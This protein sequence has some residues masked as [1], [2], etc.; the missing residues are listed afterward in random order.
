MDGVG[1]Q[2]GCL[3]T[4]LM[5]RLVILCVTGF[6]LGFGG[7]DFSPITFMEVNVGQLHNTLPPS[8][9]I[10]NSILYCLSKFPL[11]FPFLHEL[12]TT[13]RTVQSHCSQRHIP[14]THQGSGN[15]IN[16]GTGVL[17]NFT[18]SSLGLNGV[19]S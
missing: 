7:S 4:K 13:G 16:D 2:P 11:K 17:N 9:K 19:V 3:T 10:L 18:R 14:S 6:C 15:V 8:L 12:S 1:F 5:P